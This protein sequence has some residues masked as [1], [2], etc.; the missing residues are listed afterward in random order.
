MEHEN[1][2][3]IIKDKY[4]PD[5][6]IIVLGNIIGSTFS[7]N[8]I[9]KIIPGDDDKNKLLIYYSDI[10]ENK[11]YND[12]KKYAQ[13]LNLKSEKEWKI[14]TKLKEFPKNIPLAPRVV[15]KD[16]EGF[17]LFLGTGRKPRSKK[18]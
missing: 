8:P 18:S 9:I 11:S 2:K 5:D 17:D 6:N 14:H 7:K 1:N 4:K 16:F 15:Y 10:I 13:S 12:A 3:E